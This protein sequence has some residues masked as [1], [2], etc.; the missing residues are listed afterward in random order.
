MG[1]EPK[2]FAANGDLLQAPQLHARASNQGLD[3]SCEEINQGA[4]YRFHIQLSR[5]YRACIES[6]KL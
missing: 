6:Y 1:A 5:E 3:W 2:I 4:I